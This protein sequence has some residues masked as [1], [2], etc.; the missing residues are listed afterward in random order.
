MLREALK[1]MGRANLIGSGPDQ[2]I[3]AES[4]FR[5]PSNRGASDRTKRFATQ[6]TGLPKFDKKPGSSA[7]KSSRR[8][9]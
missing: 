1:R 2:L 9:S 3:P 8:G 7:R 4:S 6:H 5:G